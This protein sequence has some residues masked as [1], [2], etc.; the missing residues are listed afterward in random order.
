MT[1]A[2]ATTE[3]RLL[4][5]GDL[6]RLGPIV[7]SCFAPQRIEGV[8][9]Y[10][11]AIAEIPRS[12][13]RAV[14][15]GF[16]VNCRQPEAAI[17]AMKRVAGESP[18]V[19]C[20]EPNYESLGR[21]LTQHGADSYVIFPPEA[22]DLEEALG[23][24]SRRT[25]RRWVETP[26]ITPAPS[27]EELAR[28]ADLLP[29]LAEGAT[30]CL[31]AM[32]ALVAAALHAHDAAVV[33]EGRTGIAGMGGF[34]AVLIEPILQENRP[35][36]QIRV[37]ARRDESLVGQ[38]D[39]SK[40]AAS[41]QPYTHDDTAKLR[42][43]GVLFGRLLE[44]ARRTDQLKTLAY[45]DDLTGLPNRRRLLEFLEEKLSLAADAQATVTALVFDIDDFKRYN[46]TY[47]HDA[48]DEIL[49]EVGK[50]FVQCCRKSDLVARY[51]G[52]EFVVVFWDPEGP[53]TAGSQHP[54]AFRAVV[55]RFREALR[56]HSFSRLGPE[57]VG[58]LTISGGLAHFPW[59]ARTAHELIKAAD[60]ALLR[61]KEAGKNRFWVTGE[62]AGPG[63]S[64]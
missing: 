44:S 58:C 48:G 22:I 36:G 2:D 62:G 27:P 41:T 7:A 8:H 24:P 61:A 40:P 54:H 64:A 4:V 52:D 13:T 12:P 49:I 17:A 39:S 33:L 11:E 15:V 6:P 38:L 47:G 29:K 1:A 10:L 28:M 42:H 51:G 30:D 56:S 26:A 32:A 59:Q 19:F 57:A 34:A 9:T 16:E 50:L 55:D 46:D 35:I 45:T 31:D 20:C 37:G 53:R 3:R 63:P 23:I 43:Y 21:R 5:V 14:L 25:Q 18:V 60:Q